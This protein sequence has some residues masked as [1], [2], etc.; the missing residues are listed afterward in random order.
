MANVLVGPQAGRFSDRVGR[1]G[2]ILFSCVGLSL[3]MAGTPYVVNS[4]PLAYPW[5][6][7]V[8]GLVAMR[9]GPF[10][11]LLT[12]LVTDERRGS[13]MSLTVAVGQVGFAA[14]GTLAGVFYAT[15]GYGPTTLIAALSVLGM[16]FVVWFRV[17]EPGREPRG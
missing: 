12:A 14:G 9:M 16:G 13:L 17:P 15:S 3:V 5:F 10:S 11:A 8:M 2:L 4:V 7:L 6:F 1:K